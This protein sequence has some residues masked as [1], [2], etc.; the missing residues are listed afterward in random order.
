MTCFMGAGDALCE[1]ILIHTSVKLVTIYS[2]Y[3]FSYPVILIHTSVKLV[4]FYQRAGNKAFIILIHT[5]VKLVT[6]MRI[7]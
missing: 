4:T 3:Y 7:R 1:A 2:K 6:Q 5:S